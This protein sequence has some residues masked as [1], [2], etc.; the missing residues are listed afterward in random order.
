MQDSSLIPV[1]DL[2]EAEARAEWARLAREIK[3]HDERYHGEDAPVID[4][5]AYDAMRGRNAAIEA[6]F[7][8]LVRDDSPAKRVGATPAGK[9]RKGAHSRPTLSLD[10]ASSADAVSEFSDGAPAYSCSS[11]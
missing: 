1:E 9:F 7:P 4:D 10:N 3:F 6:R 5:A 8:K 11:V 2:D